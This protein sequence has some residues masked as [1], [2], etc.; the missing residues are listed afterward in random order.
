[1]GCDPL[2]TGEAA[3]CL[4]RREARIVRSGPTSHPR[5]HRDEANM[6]AKKARP[7]TRRKAPAPGPDPAR[8]PEPAIVGLG[9]SAG[10]LLALEQFFGSVQPSLG[11]AYV[12]V[13]HLDPE[14]VSVLGELLQRVCPLPVVEVADGMKVQADTVHVIP[15]NREMEVF[16]GTLLLTVPSA[17]RGQ[18]MAVDGFFRSLADERGSGAIGVVLSGTGSDGAQGLR[19]IHDA[20]GSCLVQDPATARFGGMPAAALA[21]VPTSRIAAADRLP[22]LLAGVLRAAPEPGRVRPA[23]GASEAGLRRVL[24]AVRSA[25]GRDFSQYKRSSV[26]RRVERRM[27]ACALAD[28]EA[29]ARHLREHPAE[30]KV[31]FRELLLNVTAFFRD[32][33]AF[34]RLQS[35][36]L[37]RLVA[38]KPE[39]EP[40]RIWVAGCASGEEAYSVAILLQ[41]LMDQE[42]RERLVQIYA[43]D[44]DAE[45]VSQARAGTYSDAA[46]AGVSKDRLQRFFARQGEG[47]RVKKEIRDRVVFAVQDLIKDPPFTRLD[48]ACCRN[49]FIYLE[50]ELQERL[51]ALFHYALR[52]GGALLL[53]PAE[54]TGDSELFTPIDRRW[55]IFR[56]VLRP[57]GARELPAGESRWGRSPT[58]SDEV[59]KAMP[60]DFAEVARRLL[61]QHHAPPSVLTDQAGTLLYVHGDTGPYLRLAPGQPTLRVAEMA[62]E[63][64]QLAIRAVLQRAAATGR[65]ERRKEVRFTRNGANHRVDLVARPAPAARG[66]KGLLLLSFLPGGEPRAT[67][68]GPSGGKPAA[69]GTPRLEEVRRELAYTRETLQATIEEQQAS[70]EELQ[71]TN[72][73]LQSTNEEFQASNEELETAKE[74]LQSVN[75]ELTTVN[76][77]LEGKVAQ[78]SEMQDDMKNLLDAINVGTIFLDERLRIK[79]FTRDADRIYRLVP[80]DAGRPLADIKS[81]VV[82]RD[83]LLEAQQVLDTLVPVERDVR[84]ADGGWFMARLLPY[85]TTDNAIRGVVMTFTDVRRRMEAEA[86]ARAG[87][88]LAERIVDTVREP[89]LVL[90]GALHAVFASRAFHETFGTTPETIAGRQVYELAGR[91][92]DLAALRDL[93]ERKLPHDQ[94]SERLPIDAL[95]PD[96]STRRLLL[97]G[98]RISGAPGAAQLILLV[99]GG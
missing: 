83:L 23:A 42:H 77:E 89:L 93:L 73:E 80:T 62:S 13:Q 68:R 27:A 96:G 61:L 47:W 87:R 29:Y 60:N 14:H 1:M 52:P 35:Q 94:G 28:V 81:N 95:L 71:S 33:E 17:P 85:R 82:E 44:L 86:A 39:G 90:D 38:G 49:V 19:A 30:V 74:E 98:R 41:E 59:K 54:G 40:I 99:F 2:A 8:L 31:L 21:A 15:P 22:A 34:D 55:R 36:V 58:G 46:V 67:G 4:A 53:S 48:L 88:E 5:A 63:G 20:G 91:R 11:L 69:R 66:P 18:R 76:A 65:P 70:H 24:A 84:C 79:R 72:E 51:L 9:A 56:A 12:V 32:P 37:A 43:T 3:P 75:E 6:P 16:D 64:L 92:L 10:G 26:V 97:E 7:R 57:R 50:P 78:L 45:A 25:T